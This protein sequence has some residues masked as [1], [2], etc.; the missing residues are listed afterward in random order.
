MSILT[1]ENFE[2]EER[3]DKAFLQVLRGIHEYFNKYGVQCIR[4]TTKVENIMHTHKPEDKT[5]FKQ[6]IEK[7]IQSAE[8]AINNPNQ[9]EACLKW[10]KYFGPRFSCALA[11]E[12][13]EGAE[14]QKQRPYIGA[15]HRTA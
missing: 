12:T 7:F 11:V 1:A 9:K 10:Q 8:Q 6:D 3:D 14:V 4:P 5:T 13:P 2:L 15:S